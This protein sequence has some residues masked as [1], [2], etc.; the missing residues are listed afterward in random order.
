MAASTI[1]VGETPSRYM[2][3]AAPMGIQQL[4]QLILAVLA[5]VS[6]GT[7][8]RATT[9]GRTPL[10]TA[11]T[12][13]LP[14]TCW[15]KMASPMMMRMGTRMLPNTAVTAPRRP[16]KRWP[17]CVAILTANTP[18]IACETAIISIKVSLSIH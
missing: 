11:S 13:A 6:T 3:R 9:A 1:Q 8:M 12:T 17:T 14:R 16:R 10:K 7:A 2:N 5:S 15:K 4:R 18:G